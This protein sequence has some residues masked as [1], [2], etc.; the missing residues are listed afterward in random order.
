MF[1]EDVNDLD[2][3]EAAKFR[4]LLEE[5]AKEFNCKLLLFEVNHGSVS[6]SFDN[7]ELIAKILSVFGET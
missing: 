3:P 1:D 2:H 6:F 7:D 5:V 4:S